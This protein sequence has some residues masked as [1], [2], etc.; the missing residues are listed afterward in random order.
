MK[1]FVPTPEHVV[2]KMVDDLF[3]R[4][5][6]SVDRCLLDP[7][8]GDGAFIDGV[9]RWC[10]RKDLPLPRITGVEMHPARCSAAKKEFLRHPGV[11]IVEADFLLGQW[12]AFDYVIGNPPFVAITGLS[13][14]EKQNYRSLYATAKGRFDLYLLFFE[15]GIRS[16]KRDGRIVFITPEKYLAVET[17]RPLRRILAQKSVRGISFL[18]EDTFPGLV[19]YPVQKLQ[20]LSRRSLMK[21]LR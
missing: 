21:P 10:N 1:G 12:G 8:C 18:P 20:F 15:K 13:D 19:T 3:A 7:G 11:Q 2:D 4:T 14:E 17:A 5:P 16:L 9:I 6:P